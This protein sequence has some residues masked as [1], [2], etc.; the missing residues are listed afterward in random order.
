[1]KR[2]FDV[3]YRKQ[4]AGGRSSWKR[5]K[6][7]TTLSVA[8][9]TGRRLRYEV[10]SSGKTHEAGWLHESRSRIELGHAG[11]K[12]ELQRTTLCITAAGDDGEPSSFCGAPTHPRSPPAECAR[13]R[14]RCARRLNALGGCRCG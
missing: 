3:E 2:V 4:S 7:A 10:C 8:A 1:M 6:A 5:C 13:S 11:L 12:A 9:D 14:A